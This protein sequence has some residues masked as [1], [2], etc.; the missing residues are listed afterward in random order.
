MVRVPHVF[1]GIREWAGQGSGL[2]SGSEQDAVGG[3]GQ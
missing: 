3:A 1:K 2:Q